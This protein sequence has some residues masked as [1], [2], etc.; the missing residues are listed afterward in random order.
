MVCLALT[1]S[2]PLFSQTTTGRILGSVTDTT[3]A[4]VAG[5]AVVVTDTQR[6][7][8]RAAAT[9]AS[10]DYVVPELQPGVYKVKAE[11]KGFKAVERVNITVEVA[12]DLRV[13][14]TLPT[15]QVSETV[16]VTDVG[17]AGQQHLVDPRRYAQQR[18]DQRLPAQWP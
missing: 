13:D 3:G 9:D 16:V 8:T 15:G 17:S 2:A 7:T 12:Q 10:G 11:A 1:L 14:V 5:A 18:R 6:G 4:A